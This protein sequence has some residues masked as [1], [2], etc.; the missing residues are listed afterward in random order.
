MMLVLG[1]MIIF[2]KL[3]LSTMLS[4]SIIQ[5]SDSNLKP[6]SRKVQAVGSVLCS[7]VPRVRE[8]ER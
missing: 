5:L 8:N 3:L 4:V 2:G 1:F 6:E 7:R